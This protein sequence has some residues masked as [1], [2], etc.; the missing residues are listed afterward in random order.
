[1]TEVLLFFFNYLCPYIEKNEGVVVEEVS[2]HQ[3]SP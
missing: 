2:T 3:I 1:M